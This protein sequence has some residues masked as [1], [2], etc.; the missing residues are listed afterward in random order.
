MLLPRL[1]ALAGAALALTA[2]AAPPAVAAPVRR[3]TGA[4][5]TPVLTSTP[6][7]ALPGQRVTHTITLAV[8]GGGAVPGVRVT[9][10]TSADLVLVAAHTSAGRCPTV[11]ARTVVCDLGTL[12]GP[13]TVRVQGVLAAGTAPGALVSNVVTVSSARPDANPADDRADNAYLLPP[14]TATASNSPAASA[15]PAGASERSTRT[16]RPVLALVAAVALAAL[17]AGGL[18]VRRRRGALTRGD[19]GDPETVV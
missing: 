8:T 18:L 4:D 15:R 7:G 19:A 2:A 11:G 5:V 12:S 16:G 14:P 1:V 17:V 3:A 6:F 13:A 9:F 10:T